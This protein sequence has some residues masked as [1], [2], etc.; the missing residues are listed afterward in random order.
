ML[1]EAGCG[2]GE[3]DEQEVMWQWECGCQVRINRLG[4]IYSI[5]RINTALYL[6][7]INVIYS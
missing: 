2:S 3:R 4:F 7:Y 1:L 6:V 5:Y